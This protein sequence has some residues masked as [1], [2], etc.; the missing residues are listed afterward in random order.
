M[1]LKATLKDYTEPEFLALLAKIW[2]VDLPKEQHDRLINHFDQ[3][4]GHPKGA[5]LLFYPEQWIESS[6]A[7]G[8]MLLIRNWHHKQGDTALK[9]DVLPSTIRPVP[10]SQLSSNMAEIQS[11]SAI[12]ATS[13]QRLEAAFGH[14]ERCITQ[15]RGQQSVQ[16]SIAEQ[17]TRIR[18][19]ES[20]QVVAYSA[21]RAVESSKMRLEFSVTRTQNNLKYARSEQA[22]WQGQLQQVS[23]IYTRCIA[24]IASGGQ[25]YR[26]LLGEANAL[27]KA[28]EAQLTSSRTLAGVGPAQAASTVTASLAFAGKRPDM[29][30]GDGQVPLET[31][32]RVDLQKSIRSAVAELTWQNTAE[33][34]VDPG[35]QAA[36]LQFVFS[37]HADT[38]VYGVSVPLIEL[39]AIE[40][41]YWQS[42]A[43]QRAEVEIP[44]RMNTAVV[45]AKAGST[46]LGV[47]G[48]TTMSQVCIMSAPVEASV[49]RIRVRPAQR[50][51]NG[52]SFSFTADGV[53]PITVLWA[54]PIPP[55]DG[56]STT[57][58]PNRL[59]IVQSPPVPRVETST[60][61]GDNHFDDYIVVFPPESDL[62]PLY[63]MFRNRL[64]YPA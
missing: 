41:Q 20:A 52:R 43:N 9:G 17:M 42:L 6:G 38:Q 8:V 4:V 46:L 31:S 33:R 30:M 19:L 23:A 11:H 27:L 26:V 56:S 16:A 44:F 36:V 29:L 51:G 55:H 1:E 35:N 21:L 18:G 13:E 54:D 60:G 47:E 22:L 24:L 14:F 34:Q 59:R 49:S 62:D 28:A 10:V 61:I 37:S 57:S 45:T 64:E 5:D 53:A 2:A 7:S 25:R 48:L 15:Q 40:G 39:M 63:V 32:Q 50:D 58:T 3:I 12:M